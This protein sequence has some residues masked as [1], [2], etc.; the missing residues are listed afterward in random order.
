[1]TVKRPE[2][3][4]SRKVYTKSLTSIDKSY[5]STDTWAELLCGKL[6]VYFGEFR[7]PSVKDIYTTETGLSYI[8]RQTAALPVALVIWQL[9]V[10][11]VLRT[12]W[13]FTMQ[14]AKGMSG[15]SHRTSYDCRSSK[16]WMWLGLLVAGECRGETSTGKMIGHLNSIF[17][18]I[19]YMCIVKLNI[20]FILIVI[21][22]NNLHIGLARCG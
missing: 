9:V 11:F 18:I 22:L 2:K 20:T 12:P 4:L 14:A 16:E 10:Y 17:V 6:G 8:D 15:L 19:H 7:K 5:R 3:T 13:K 1:M 21:K